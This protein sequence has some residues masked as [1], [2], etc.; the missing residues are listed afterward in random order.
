MTID[1]CQPPLG[2]L[3]RVPQENLD[4]PLDASARARAEEAARFLSFERIGGVASCD[5]PAAFETAEI[6]MNSIGHEIIHGLGYMEHAEVICS[7]LT[8][9]G[10]PSVLVLT[11]R[12]IR[13]TIERLT[14]P[15][16]ANSGLAGDLVANVCAELVAP[17]GIISVH[18]EDGKMVVRARHMVLDFKF[19]DLV[20]LVEAASPANAASGVPLEQIDSISGT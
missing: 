17:G 1:Y 9:F 7:Y 11:D 2:Y 20:E 3:V 13:A 19:T 5:L 14:L 16:Q 6:I 4:S 8:T 15:H 18:R 12:E 10:G